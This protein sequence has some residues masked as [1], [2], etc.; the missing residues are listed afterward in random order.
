MIAHTKLLPKLCAG[1]NKLP[2]MTKPCTRERFKFI[3]S[4]CANCIN[5]FC[6]APCHCCLCFLSAFLFGAMLR[7]APLRRPPWVSCSSG[8]GSPS[9]AFLACVCRICNAAC[10]GSS[11]EGTACGSRCTMEGSA[12]GSRCI[13]E[14]SVGKNCVSKQCEPTLVAFGEN[15]VCRQCEPIWQK[16]RE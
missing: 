8:L 10:G 14:G 15:C 3:C 11:M 4:R 6:H 5:I 13:M 9:F 7:S 2:F 1:T 16:L 12:C